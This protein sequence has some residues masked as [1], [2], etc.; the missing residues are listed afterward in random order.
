ML[1]L[2]ALLVSI[3][4]VGT[5]TI[6]N[7]SEE[8]HHSFIANHL[9]EKEKADKGF[10]KDLN[11]EAD[12]GFMRRLFSVLVDVGDACSDLNTLGRAFFQDKNLESTIK[13]AAIESGVR[14]NLYL[15]SLYRFEY[16][17]EIYG[18]VGAFGKMWV[19]TETKV[20][21]E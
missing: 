3:G 21:S 18:V 11:L 13:K 14:D 5:M 16:E 4:L 1:K 10:C 12:F 19:V 8:S 6:L 15:G 17:G 20:P 7:P 9:Y 2:S